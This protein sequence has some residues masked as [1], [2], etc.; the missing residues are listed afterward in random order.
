ML[1]IKYHLSRL[2]HE[3]SKFHKFIFLSLHNFRFSRL[4]L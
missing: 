2:Y 1:L 4:T 3:L